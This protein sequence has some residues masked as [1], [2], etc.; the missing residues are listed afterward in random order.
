MSADGVAS[1]GLI[2]RIRGSYWDFAGAAR[3]LIA[4]RPS[5]TTLLSFVMLA[6]LILA[7]G[8]VIDF[9]A[10]QDPA[11]P[12]PIEQVQETLLGILISFFLIGA[13][14]VYFFSMMVT[15]A[16]RAFGGAGSYYETR[17][18]V[19]WGV[20]VSAPPLFVQQ[21]VGA[22]R[23]VAERDLTEGA[24]VA[25]SWAGYLVETALLALAFVIWAGSIAGAHGFTSSSRVLRVILV[26]AIVVAAVAL[27]ATRF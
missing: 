2:G 9:T 17:A 6:M 21:V 15:L 1:D 5:E 24:A 8:G 16:A 3:R 12:L 14:A 13:L 19:I 23:R 25:A 27:G 18:G 20:L 22:V 7:F 4:E 10:R 11:A 26:A